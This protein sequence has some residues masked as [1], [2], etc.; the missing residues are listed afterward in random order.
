MMMRDLKRAFPEQ[1]VEWYV[2]GIH[3]LRWTESMNQMS[4]QGKNNQG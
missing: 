4:S 2:L 1:C 3:W